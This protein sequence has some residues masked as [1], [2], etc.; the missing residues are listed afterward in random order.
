MT[1]LLVGLR[2]KGSLLNVSSVTVRDAA[3][4]WVASNTQASDRTRA[5]YRRTLD[6]YL[7]EGDPFGDWPAGVVKH[8]DVR[9]WIRRLQDR[10]VET[11]RADS[12]DTLSAKRATCGGPP[13]QPLAAPRGWRECSIAS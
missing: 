2:A 10:Q 4:S 7:P 3:L 12:A 5:E 6:R 8:S 9:K 1:G 11:K 13:R